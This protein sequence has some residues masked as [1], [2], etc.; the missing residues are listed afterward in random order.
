MSASLTIEDAVFTALEEIGVA[1][2]DARRL[3]APLLDLAL[4]EDITFGFVPRVEKNLGLQLPLE[5]WE[6]VYTVA[7][8]ILVLQQH[9]AKH[10]GIPGH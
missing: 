2:E 6:S 4:D 9:A 7:D 5:A 1:P 8:A 3:D 10:R